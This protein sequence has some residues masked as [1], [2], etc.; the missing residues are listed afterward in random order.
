MSD[1]S[2]SSTRLRRYRRCCLSICTTVFV[3]PNFSDSHEEKWKK[4]R[5]KKKVMILSL[6]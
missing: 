4:K 1:V 3:F 6:L 2:P 5:K